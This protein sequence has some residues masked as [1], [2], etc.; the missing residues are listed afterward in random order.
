MAQRCPPWTD[1][2]IYGLVAVRI[3]HLTALT[4]LTVHEWLPQGITEQ[5]QLPASL[6][7]LA[8]VC[9]SSA[10]PL[11]R[12]TQ[13]HTL[14]L[15][16][17]LHNHPGQLLQLSSLP[18]LTAL[19]VGSELS[20]PAGLRP[21]AHAGAAAAVTSSSGPPLRVS[22]ADLR[23]YVH[24]LATVPVVVPSGSLV[25]VQRQQEQ[26]EVAG[27]Q[28]AAE[29]RECAAALAGLRCLKGLRELRLDRQPATRNS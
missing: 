11:L 24:L 28:G 5:Y 4:S 26:G 19:H 12:L 10:R 21:Q 22:C 2:D 14:Q 27:V 8:A 6:Q 29:Q 9:V 18:A 15:S 17:L 20:V 7:H 25:V 3:S 13:L 1:D 23:E 16:S